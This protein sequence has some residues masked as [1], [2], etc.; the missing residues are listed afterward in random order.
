MIIPGIDYYS[1]MLIT[2]EIGD[3]HRFISAKKDTSWAGLVLTVHQSGNTVYM[4]KI[5]K[6]VSKWLRW[7][8]VQAVQ[9][10]SLSDPRLRNYYERVKKRRGHNKAIVAVTRE[11]LTIIYHIHTRN[12]PNRGKSPRLTEQK[13][14]RLMK[15]ASE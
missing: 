1:A 9:K 3:V 7:I 11:P 8:L 6:K 5:T 12:E 15:K 14:K 10:A 2:A 4:E 13:Y